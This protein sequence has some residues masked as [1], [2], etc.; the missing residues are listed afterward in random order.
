MIKIGLIGAGFMGGTHAACYEMLMKEMDIKVVAVADLSVENAEKIAGKLGAEVYSTGEELLKNADINVADICLPTY[1]HATHAIMA[2]EQGFDVLIEKP[3]CLSS[4][5]AQK[6]LEVQKSTNAKVG[7]GHCIRFWDEYEYL[8]KLVENKTYGKFI[9]ANFK[10]VSPKP[11]W[12]WNNWILDESKS[13]GAALDLHIHDVDF[14]RYLF[15]MPENIKSKISGSKNK[16]DHIYS[17]FE[18]ENTVISI[19]GGWDFPANFP[20]EMSY[21]VVFEE[22][23]IKFSSLENPSV[24]VYKNDGTAFQPDFGED[25]KESE[26]QSA[27]NISSLGGYYNELKYFYGCLSE[28]KLIENA[29]LSEAVES[30]NL[31]LNE[32]EKGK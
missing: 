8:K 3:V 15:G 2:M 16:K 28:N 5:E 21:V 27:G 29:S 31:T 7:V 26:K 14:V 13:G 25:I 12:T 6:L 19:E 30:L 20:F 10:R 1:L 24:N 9:S 11:S 32:I 23:C 22:A 17:I 18:Y 4:S